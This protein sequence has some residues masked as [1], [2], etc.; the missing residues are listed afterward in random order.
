MPKIIVRIPEKESYSYT[1]FQFDSL[2][3]YKNEYKQT[4]KVYTEFKEV[5]TAVKKLMN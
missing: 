3:E 4:L 2:E 1:E 5:S